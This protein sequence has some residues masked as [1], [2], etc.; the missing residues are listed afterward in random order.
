MI[1]AMN[2]DLFHSLPIGILVFVILLGPLMFIHELGHFLVARKAGIHVEEFGMGLPPRAIRLF[3]HG[4]TEYTLNWLPIGAFVRM[5]GEED[6]SH[7]RGFAAQPKRWRLA[8]LLAGPFMNLAFGLSLLIIAYLAFATHPTSFRYRVVAVQPNSPAEALGIQPNDEIIAV[9]GKSLDQFVDPKV[10]LSSTPLR[11]IALQAAGK[12]FTIEVLRRSAE[13]LTPQRLILSTILPHTLDPQA[14]LGLNLSLHVVASSRQ[15]YTL[16]QALYATFTDFVSIVTSMLRFPIDIIS[17]RVPLEHIRPVGPIG[18]TSIGIAMLE[19][20]QTQGLFPFIRFAALISILVGFTNLLPIPALDGG[21]ALF[22]VIEALRGRRL[23]PRYERRV[24]SVS[25]MILISL[26][27][28][29]MFLD[30]TVPVSV[31]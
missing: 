26:S 30:I 9:N 19:E 3:K 10:A 6:P 28:A 1:K 22:I 21:R 29:I 27:I 18:I 8:V 2:L 24:N 25:L 13:S 14:P 16:S 31:R 11:S 20:R 15:P 17:Q 4:D 12:P 23:H 5:I 7:P